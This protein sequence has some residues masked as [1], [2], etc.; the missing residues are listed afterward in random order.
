[1][2]KLYTAKNMVIMA[3]F[4]AIGIILQIIENRIFIS[5]VPG[6]KLG[7]SNIV[8]IINIFMFGGRNALVI[9][10]VRAFLG[11]LLSGGVTA[12]PYSIA[13]T[14]FSVVA[15]AIIKKYFYPTVSMIGISVVG[16]AFYNFAQILVASIIFSSG[17]MFSYLS[18]LLIVAA[19]SGTVTGI[20]A[21][22]L[23]KRLL[24]MEL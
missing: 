21:Q 22:I 17:Y 1:M 6:G 14:F 2:K 18:Q 3:V 24:E 19:V 20:G 23:G 11:T 16:A 15:M 5:P 10:L 4:A 13:G 9:S 7:L 12:I 8:S